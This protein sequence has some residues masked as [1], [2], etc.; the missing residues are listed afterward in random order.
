MVYFAMKV[1][2]LCRMG[3]ICE[4]C[5][6]G[7]DTSDLAQKL[8]AKVAPVFDGERFE[9]LPQVM[10][11]LCRQQQRLAYR[12]ESTL[13]KAKCGLTR[14]SMISTYKE[15]SPFTV[16]SQ[17][18]FWSD[19]WDAMDYGQDFDFSRPFFE[20][21]HELMLKVPR[22][23][24]VNKQSENSDYCNYSFSNKNC[25]LLFGSH[26]EEDCLYGGYSTK[27]KDCMDYFWLYGS[28]LCYEASFSAN[29]HRSAFIDRCEET[30]ESYF[31]FDLRGCQ[32]CLFSYN[33]RNKQ[34]CIFNEQKTK[35]EYEQYLKDLH[36]DSWKQLNKLK[37]DWLDFVQKN[38]IYKDSF[39]VNCENCE[40][41]NHQNSKNLKYC[42]ACTNCEDSA[43]G[44]QMDETYGSV[45]NSHMGYDKCELCY[46]AV[47]NNGTYQG[48][49]V[50]S[51]WH[52]SN[53]TYANLC[54]SSKDLFGC[55]GLRQKQYCILNKQYSKE[56]YE[57][58][59]NK[60]AKHM[61]ETGEWGRFFP[62]DLRPFAYNESVVQQFFLLDKEQVLKRGWK[63]EDDTSMES[64]ASD[65][66]YVL[67]D[68]I[69][70]VD[71]EV[72][73]KILKCER[74]GNA[75]KVV[76][77]ELDFYRKLGLPVAKIS[78]R[79]R[80][81]ERFSLKSI[82]FFDVNCFKCEKDLETTIDPSKY[83]KIYCEECYLKEVY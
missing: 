70:D 69:K 53:V 41:T 57:K 55:V 10:C 4:Q 23:S 36:L 27:N 14:D 61:V 52:C 81:N 34:Y 48:F 47:G 8:Y 12:N 28:E 1:Y 15:S 22:L 77:K 60:I 58:L 46:Q 30:S 29:C 40:G 80:L 19:G 6:K 20:Q 24:I 26:Y 3:Q 31:C 21:F 25:Y 65:A 51:C 32:N 16:Y 83:K 43:Y 2:G 35:E 66:N 82:N 42:F 78:P 71:D 67:P 63:W 62:A 79:E 9:P 56:E 18:A 49:C 5:G 54:F 13:Y 11:P 73:S 72:L 59:A 45:D 68:R 74:S 39:Q 37:Y 7:F 75:Y 50:D 33:L 64:A 44:F 17:K 38:A 76:K